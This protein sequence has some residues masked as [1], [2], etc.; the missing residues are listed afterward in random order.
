MTEV[1]WR[2]NIIAA[3]QKKRHP[4]SLVLTPAAAPMAR[5]DWGP[6]LGKHFQASCRGSLLLCLFLSPMMMARASR[7][8]AWTSNH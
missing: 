6:V 4:L 2:L 5:T 7:G 1:E 8:S 3:L